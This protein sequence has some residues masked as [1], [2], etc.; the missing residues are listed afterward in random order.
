[1]MHIAAGSEG[2]KCLKFLIE[3]GENVNSL[4]NEYDRAT[5]L[6]FAAMGGNVE[7]AK[8]LL[9]KNANPNAKDSV[10]TLS[11]PLNIIQA[12]NT[13]MHL[14]VTIDSFPL[15]K[16]LDDYG[17]DATIKNGEEVCPIEIAE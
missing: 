3:K 1:M 13:A 17:A 16:L 12:G 15:V 9:K 6:Q 4:S 10:I 14:A 8:I 7:N 2:S 5:P 11:S